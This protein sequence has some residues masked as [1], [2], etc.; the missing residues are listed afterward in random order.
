MPARVAATDQFSVSVV[1]DCVDY[2]GADLRKIG[3]FLRPPPA[4]VGSAVIF[5]P[6]IAVRAA[7]PTIEL[8]AVARVLQGLGGGGLMTL[9]QALVG[10]AIPPR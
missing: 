2:R 1:P 8:L 5:H 3:R 9:S 10:E 6:G 4:D 7:S